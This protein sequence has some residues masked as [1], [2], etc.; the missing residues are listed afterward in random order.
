MSVKEPLTLRFLNTLSPESP[1]TS[2]RGGV[3]VE[4]TVNTLTLCSSYV[5]S[6][7]ST[8][9][10]L[11]VWDC[12][13]AFAGSGL[14]QFQQTSQAAAVSCTVPG[15]GPQLKVGSADTY[16]YVHA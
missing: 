14:Q 6:F 3:C 4:Y 10:A 7:G 12:R 1:A 11:D 5:E 8:Y 15:T 13:D 16:L 9:S 2:R